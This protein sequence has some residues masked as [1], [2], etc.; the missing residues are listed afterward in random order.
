VLGKRV[1]RGCKNMPAKLSIAG[2][3]DAAALVASVSH[4]ISTTGPLVRNPDYPVTDFVGSCFLRLCLWVDLITSW[5]RRKQGLPEFPENLRFSPIAK[6]P[7]TTDAAT[8][9]E[10]LSQ[11]GIVAPETLAGIHR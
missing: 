10:A 6:V 2:R 9:A 3:Q 4:T 7:A 1:A 5:T 11:S 8:T